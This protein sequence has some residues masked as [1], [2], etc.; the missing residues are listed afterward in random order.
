M[1][2]QILLF[3]FTI[4]LLGFI[5]A[6]IIINS[7]PADIYNSGDM[8]KIPAKIKAENNIDSFISGSLLCDGQINE[9]YKEFISLASGEEK[10]IT[11][12]IPLTVAT[13]GKTYG[14]CKIKFSLG[15]EYKLT[16]EFQVSN[17][18]NL[19]IKE[20]ATEYA[21]GDS[22]TIS[23]NAIKENQEAS[24]GKINLKIISEGE[25]KV[26]YQDTIHNGYFEITTQIP[27]D[28]AAGNYLLSIEAVETKGENI[29]NKGFINQNIQIKQVP[30][31]LELITEQEEIMPKETLNIKA[32]LHDQTGE[33]IEKKVSIMVKDEFENILLQQ[34][35]S[36]TSGLEYPIASNHKPVKL[37][38][39]AKSE[40]LEATGEIQVLENPEVKVD[41]INNTLIVQNIGNIPYNDEI[42][43]L[44]G[45]QTI[46]FNATLKLREEK[47]YLLTAP[48][49]TYDIEILS[50][51]GESIVNKQQ[52]LLTGNAIAIK[53]T[54]E[55]IVKISSHP[56]SWIFIIIILILVALII[57]KKGYKK[58]F[59]G[60][61]KNRKNK[62]YS[63]EILAVPL[64]KDSL[65]KTTN[66]AKVS[67]S[68]HGTKQNAD[69]ISLQIKNLK[70]I[71]SKKGVIE[72]TLQK[73]INLAENMKAVIY[74]NQ[75]N[76]VFILSPLKTKTFKNEKIA[77]KLAQEIQAE[78]ENHNKTFKE[79]IDYGIAIN[80]GT[81]I[82][83][84][85]KNQFVFMSMGTFIASAKKLAGIS[86][87]EL[88]LSK[89]FR[90]KTIAELKTEK[91]TQG[92]LDYYTILEIR[93]DNEEN[94]KF[95]RNFMDRMKED[96]KEK[97]QEK[98]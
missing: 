48:E 43:A 1:K 2:K 68:L 21:P 39:I 42:I 13:M 41:L 79:K 10:S 50:S 63:E 7:E 58:S 5:S 18:I 57:F 54:S 90:N 53:E 26:K 86:K 51:Q 16:K 52:V 11:P 73:I 80:S 23:G 83:K 55:T 32:I 74:E 85:E 75:N 17:L 38:I 89:N 27:E 22:I 35:I 37:I 92:N 67:L 56:L 31:N 66:P 71:E 70:E 3:V 98:K 65:V 4:L 40:G 95:I 19:E 81:I 78:L 14:T 77:V 49:G 33:N 44:I 8:I 76:I 20:F 36:T 87:G 46:K 97:S 96:K 82:A 15:E 25:E 47:T 30:S 61:I 6:E 72:E 9:V 60:Y 45:N 69:L 28:F 84:Q 59:I 94:K 24:N 93:K 88:I 62:K 64:K 12:T 34:E 29:T 91:H